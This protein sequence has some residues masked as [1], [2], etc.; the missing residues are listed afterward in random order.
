MA[1]KENAAYATALGLGV[2]TIVETEQVL[3]G[4][5]VFLMYMSVWYEVYGG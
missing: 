4:V 1:V 5:L 3:A 2:F